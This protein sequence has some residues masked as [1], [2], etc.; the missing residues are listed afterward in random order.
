MQCRS[1]YKGNK[2]EGPVT[3]LWPGSCLHGIF[4]FENPRWEDYD[5]VMFHH[6]RFAYYGDGWTE[7]ERKGGDILSYM[8]HIDYPPLPG[9]SELRK[10]STI[11]DGTIPYGSL[12][13]EK[14]TVPATQNG[15]NPVPSV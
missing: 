4:A 1:W 9:E 7:I 12:V 15:V 13:R 10:V 14:Q 5:Y 8:D 6:N 11:F 3:A 2:E